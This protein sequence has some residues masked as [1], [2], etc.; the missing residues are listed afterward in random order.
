MRA[1]YR[2]GLRAAASAVL[3]FAFLKLEDIGLAL[4]RFAGERRRRRYEVR[5]APP[6][7][8]QPKAIPK[9]ADERTM[10]RIA[11]AQNGGISSEEGMNRWLRGENPGGLHH[12]APRSPDEEADMMPPRER[13]D[14]EEPQGRKERVPGGER[15]IPASR[16]GA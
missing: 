8:R 4:L 11:E 7:Q 5:L 10:R 15:H 1:R 3:T 16:R 13:P 12:K 2:R 14:Q 6:D 9:V